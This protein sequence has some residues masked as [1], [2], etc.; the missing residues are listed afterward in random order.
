MDS[1]NQNTLIDDMDMDMKLVFSESEDEETEPIK[2]D[3]NETLKSNT[4]NGN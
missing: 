3:L 4:T 1:N 2:N